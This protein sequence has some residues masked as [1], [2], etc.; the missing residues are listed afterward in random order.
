MSELPLFA[1]VGPPDPP[2]PDHR[3]NDLETAVDAAMRVRWVSGTLRARVY[4]VI[5]SAGDRGITDLE[6]ERLAV[7]NKYAPSTVRKRR[8]E[9]WQQGRVRIDGKRDGASVWVAVPYS[10]EDA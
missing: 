1:P 6:L 7:F 9:L 2:S 8:S 5:E 10:A 4:A 3:A